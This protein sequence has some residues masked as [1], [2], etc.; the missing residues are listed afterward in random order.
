MAKFITSVLT[1]GILICVMP[2]MAFEKNK[3]LTVYDTL[4]IFD[5]IGTPVADASYKMDAWPYM[6][7]YNTS[8]E[9]KDAWICYAEDWEMYQGDC[10]NK[11]ADKNEEHDWIIINP[12]D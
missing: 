9:V 5:A 6:E 1:V 4:T 10:Y 3:I 2:T 8:S 7:F 12:F 11:T